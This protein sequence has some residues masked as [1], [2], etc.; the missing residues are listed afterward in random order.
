MKKALSAYLAM[1]MVFTPLVAAAETEAVDSG[2]P[3][4]SVAAP[5]SESAPADEA[6]DQSEEEGA[7]PSEAE[8]PAEEP[9][10]PAEEVE[11][12]SSPSDDAAPASVDPVGD[13]VERVSEDLVVPLVAD[14]SSKATH[15][16]KVELGVTY[17]H[18]G[19]DQVQVTFTGLPE[20][21]GSLTIEEVTLT[22]EQ[23]EALGAV[24]R[25]AY[26]ITSDMENGT[27]AYDLKLP[28][29]AGLEEVSGV[30]YAETVE[31]LVEE[32]EA[33]SESQVEVVS[34]EDAVVVTELDH[35]TVFV[36]TSFEETQATEP[37]VGYNGIWFTD[38]ATTEIERVPT[39]TNGVTSSTGNYHGE[40]TGYAFTRWDG[41]KSAF[42]AGGYKTRV[43]VYVDTSLSTGGA[44]KRFDFSSAVNTPAGSHRRDFIFHLGTNPSV[45]GE[46]VASASN[47]APGWP[48]NPGNS[49][50]AITASG[51]YTLEH[52][53]QDVGGVLEVT[54]NL[55]QKGNPTPVGSWV[56]SDVSDVIGATVGGNRYG[57]FVDSDFDWLAI[58]Q[59][60]IEYGSVAQNDHAVV[61]READ[62]QGW[63]EANMGAGDVAFEADVDA[64]LGDGAVNLTTQADN[65]DRASV[66]RVEDVRLA[67][68]TALGYSTKRGA[69]F[70]PEGNAA[71]R[72]RFDA[73]GDLNTTTDV[74]TLVF[75]PYWQNG[76]VGDP[77]PNEQDVWQKWDVLHGTFWASI[78]GGNSVSGMANGAGGPPFYSIPDVLAL[79]PDAQVIGISVGIGSYNQNYDVLV[80]EVI[81][82]YEAGASIETYTYDFEIALP[83]VEDISL[84]DQTPGG[85][86]GGRR[87]PTSRSGGS[88]LGATTDDGADLSCGGGL[89]L[90]AYMRQGAANDAAEVRKLQSFLTGQ[91]FPVPVTGY[92]GPLTAAAVSAFQAAHA[93]EVLKPWGVGPTGI[94]FKTTR[95]KINNIVCPGSEAFPAL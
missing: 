93:D 35:F 73:D 51:W 27:F 19:N 24:S 84:G 72:V 81:F 61:V 10:E 30:V 64:P 6:A 67:D 49:P 15:F 59:A 74:A 54:M 11:E 57:W 94:V 23:V 63:S 55:Y 69:G 28:V 33:V 88:V 87:S 89:Y 86:P 68:V 76:G 39:G 38:S 1:V 16:D 5:E 82:G 90:S 75:E 91:G 12:V 56:R 92:F 44:D 7:S 43:D 18:E 20:N 78:P 26:D 66:T 25:V 37:E 14:E 41:Y 36:V 77:A 9:A 62:M 79:H 4:E 2:T 58:D 80:D 8:Q 29:P 52:S 95:W 53:F 85:N 21:P 47:N 65:N 40:I 70:I 22:D 50:V 83:V 42:P 32:A 3:S 17:A 31:E 45:D 34:E 71:Y 60:E 13:L 48:A 46:W